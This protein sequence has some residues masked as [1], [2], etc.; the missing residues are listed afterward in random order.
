MTKTDHSP[1]YEASSNEAPIS[2]HI[3]RKKYDE[4]VAKGV[5][6]SVLSEWKMVLGNE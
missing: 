6:V 4:M 5:N 2:R 1:I 3:S